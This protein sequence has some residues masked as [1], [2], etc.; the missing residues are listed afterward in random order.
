LIEKFPLIQ[1]TWR[2]TVAQSLNAINFG[3]RNP[4]VLKPVGE[5]A[6]LILRFQIED[7]N[8]VKRQTLPLVVSVYCSLTTIIQHYNNQ[9]LN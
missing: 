3:L 4:A 9:I 8:Y 1:K 5:L 7:L 6:K 2:Q